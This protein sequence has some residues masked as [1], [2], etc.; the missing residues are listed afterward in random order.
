MFDL[1]WFILIFPGV[2]S[3]MIIVVCI[4]D[5][6][7]SFSP[8]T[9]LNCCCCDVE[10]VVVL[11]DEFVAVKNAEMISEVVNAV[12]YLVMIDLAVVRVVLV[13]VACAVVVAVKVALVCIAYEVDVVA[14]GVVVA[15]V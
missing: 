9:T 7:Y 3:A 14:V 10:L 2:L 1:I 5:L 15:V 12:A 13:A 8:G 4:W 6:L 11:V